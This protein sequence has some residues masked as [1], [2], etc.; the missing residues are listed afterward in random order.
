MDADDVLGMRQAVRDGVDGKRARVRGEH[1]ARRNLRFES[2]EDFLFEVEFFDG[3]LDDE[4]HVAHRHVVGGGHHAVE[5]GLRVGLGEH[6]P[7]RRVRENLA[8]RLDALR[9]RARVDVLQQHAQPARG[10]PLRDARAHEARADDGDL[11]DGARF[12]GVTGE[13][14]FLGA[15]LEEENAHQVARGVGLRQF[16]ERRAFQ[17]QILP[18]SDTPSAA[19]ATS[20][21]RGAAG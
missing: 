10:G 2:G 1:G 9:Q 5:P 7:F 14:G 21:A 16:D 11:F 3:G 20:M 6:A 19:V 17:A 18:A 4:V 12:A 15:F 8:D 13:F